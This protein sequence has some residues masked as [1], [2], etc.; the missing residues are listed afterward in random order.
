MRIRN[1]KIVHLTYV[2]FLFSFLFSNTL[3]FSQNTT[4]IPGAERL[5]LYLNDCKN[6]SVGIVAN[7]TSVFQDKHLVDVLLSENIDIV[8]IFCPEHGFRGDAGAG[9]LIA[10]GK[11]EITGLP[12][13]SLYGNNKKPSQKQL[14]GIDIMLFDLQ[15]VGVRFYTYISTL[16]Y[17]IEACAEANIT[18][19]ILDRPNP[20]AH[21]IDGPTLENGFE[22][23]IG[24]HHVPVVY[25]MTIGEYGLMVNG[26]KWITHYFNDENML[27]VIPVANYSHEM[28]YELP[29][30]PSP[31]L[32]NMSAI[33][34]YPSLCFFEGTCMSLGRGT[35]YPFE[36]VGHPELS[37][38]DTTFVPRSIPHA[39]PNPKLK[40]QK[41][42]GCNLIGQGYEWRYT[43]HELNFDLLISCYKELQ[44]K[45]KF[46]I[47]FFDKLAGNDRFRKQIIDNESIETIRESW[48]VDLDNFKKIRSKYLIY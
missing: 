17:I 4:I 19:I 28:I 2:I 25:G 12:I 24:M 27:K 23:F 40:D 26:E 20:N 29:V 31:N 33:W 35:D 5:E 21:Y 14:E 10:D 36:L 18:L 47:P 43:T 44:E 39:A 7:Q 16:T 48:Q 3:A 41:C 42:F 22:S 11:D 6:K 13:I 30:A 9:E 46:F 15:D 38:Y 8:K 34:M 37:N 1:F 45:D 32:K